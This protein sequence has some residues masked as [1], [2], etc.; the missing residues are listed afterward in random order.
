[1]DKEGNLYENE[2]DSSDH[3]VIINISSGTLSDEDIEKLDNLF[4][5][6]DE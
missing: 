2:D 5:H 6:E 1:M 3:A 4:N